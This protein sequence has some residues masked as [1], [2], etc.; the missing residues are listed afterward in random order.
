MNNNQ[1]IYHQGLQIK[2]LQGYIQRLEL[3]L[4]DIQLGHA[5]QT[6]EYRGIINNQIYEIDRLR[7]II[8]DLGGYY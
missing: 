3:Q 4:R 2:E 8:I 5:N 1:I 7:K 6:D